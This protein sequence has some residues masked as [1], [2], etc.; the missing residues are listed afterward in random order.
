M[1]D[2]L[3]ERQE[4]FNMAFQQDMQLYKESGIVPKFRGK[5]ISALS[6]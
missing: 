1:K 3:K 5:F 4:L 2:T 6:G